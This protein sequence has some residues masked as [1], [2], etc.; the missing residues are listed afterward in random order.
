MCG[1]NHALFPRPGYLIDIS[2]ESIAAKILFSRMLSHHAEIGLTTE[3][4]TGLIDINAEYQTVTDQMATHEQVDGYLHRR[5]HPGAAN[6]IELINQQLGSATAN[7]YAAAWHQ[8]L[9][10]MA[11]LGGITFTTPVLYLTASLTHG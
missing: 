11:T 6:P 10:R 4:I 8:A 7:R 9:D 2:C 3:Q 5:P 1:V